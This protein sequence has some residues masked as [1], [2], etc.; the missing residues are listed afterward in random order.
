MTLLGKAFVMVIL[1]S[2]VMASWLLIWQSTSNDYGAGEISKD[3]ELFTILNS[4]ISQTTDSGI[5]AIPNDVLNT[6]TSQGTA[7]GDIDRGAIKSLIDSF[8][9]IGIVRP[10][11]FAVGSILQVPVWIVGAAFT[12]III[13]LIF[14]IINFF[15]GGT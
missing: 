14:A 1:G 4:T 15:R 11:F 6:S 8:N 10:L 12:M 7:S 13:I 9:L 2:I 5:E 3:V